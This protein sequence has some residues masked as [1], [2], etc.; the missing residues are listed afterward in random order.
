MVEINELWSAVSDHYRRRFKRFFRTNL[1]IKLVM[2]LGGAVTSGGVH[3]FDGKSMESVANIIGA[4][5]AVIVALGGVLLLLSEG[6]NTDEL[7]IARQ[8]IAKAD[9]LTSEQNA[10]KFELERDLAEY[11]QKEEEYEY[12]LIR[13]TELYT[14][15]EIIR[16]FIQAII[17]AKTDD[18]LNVIRK[19]FENTETH[20]V[21]ALGFKNTDTWTLCVYEARDNE[22][23]KRKVLHCVAQLRSIPCEIEKARTWPDGVGIAGQAFATG[24]ERVTPD[25]FAEFGAPDQ[26]RAEDRERYRSMVA[27]PIPASFLKRPWGVVIATSNRVGH[28]NTNPGSG[29][30]TSEPVR[31]LAGYS[32]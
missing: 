17:L 29:I 1:T 14:S 28:F 23:L 18:P 19:I 16:G 27:V 7:E 4:A 2:I 15:M 9:A 3:L 20:I 13:C 22:E 32:V 21:N 10:R 12:S 25:Q 26:E 5:A 6:D 8:A 11:D 31:M 24:R 30:R